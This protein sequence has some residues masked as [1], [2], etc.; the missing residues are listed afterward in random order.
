MILKYDSTTIEKIINELNQVETKG[1]M[2]MKHIL[3]IV[4]L[5]NQP[6]QE[7]QAPEKNK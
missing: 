5:L 1:L 4:E 6:I 3:S 7:E 2:N